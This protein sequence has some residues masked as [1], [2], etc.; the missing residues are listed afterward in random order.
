MPVSGVHS[1]AAPVTPMPLLPP[2]A[3]ADPCTGINGHVHSPHAKL[4]SDPPW[5]FNLVRCIGQTSSIDVLLQDCLGYTA[6]DFKSALGDWNKFVVEVSDA[7]REKGRLWMEDSMSQSQVSRVCN[8]CL[9]P[10]LKLSMVPSTF[11]LRLVELACETATCH[12]MKATCES[13]SACRHCTSCTWKALTVRE[14]ASL[15]DHV[16]REICTV[17]KEHMASC[18]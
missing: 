8:I 6:L 5:H 1:T 14:F 7:Q 12:Q 15:M 17:I 13:G 16:T 18:T 11:R 10:H 4:Q 2:T 9:Q 3:R